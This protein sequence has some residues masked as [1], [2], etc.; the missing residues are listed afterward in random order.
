MGLANFLLFEASKQKEIKL[1]S[2]VLTEIIRLS[3][4]QEISE[5]KTKLYI[6]KNRNDPYFPY[7]SVF[8]R[9]ASFSDFDDPDFFDS[10][11]VSIPIFNNIFQSHDIS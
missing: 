1:S 8:C 5:S 11:T 10:P 3:K 6:D 9:L 4:H 2:A 7:F